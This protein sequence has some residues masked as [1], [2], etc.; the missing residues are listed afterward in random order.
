M[1]TVQQIADYLAWQVEVGN[2]QK[3]V[4]INLRSLCASCGLN[5]LPP[6]T[7]MTLDLPDNDRRKVVRMDVR[8]KE[9]EDQSAERSGIA[10]LIL[11]RI[12]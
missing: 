7:V 8:L 10:S 6:G 12:T 3:T 11:R 5:T 9:Q 1:A 2:G 4:Q